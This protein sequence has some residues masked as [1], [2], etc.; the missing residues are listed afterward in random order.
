MVMF[1]P[2][3]ERGPSSRA[4]RV[5]LGVVAVAALGLFIAEIA[6]N[7][8][9]VKLSA[10]LVV[11]FWT[12]LLA[13]HELGHAV[14]AHLLGWR[15]GQIVIG[16]G[17]PVWRFRAG[18][19]SVTVRMLPVEGFVRCVPTRLRR[20]QLES[21]LIYFAGPGVELLLALAVLL[22]VGPDRLFSP[23]QQYAT[24]A[25]QSLALAAT[26]QAVLNLLP[27]A[28]QSGDRVMHS[29]GLGIITSFLLPTAAYAEMIGQEFNEETQEWE[30]DDPADWWKRDG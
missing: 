9:P 4:E 11:L 10:L 2:A 13:L 16:M 3:P 25:W 15:V 24:I 7:Y 5:F 18:S 22:F 20:P 30:S 28:T 29:D 27:F 26:T 21:A 14:V 1:D 23:S 17:K 6:D 19:A 12:P 8:S